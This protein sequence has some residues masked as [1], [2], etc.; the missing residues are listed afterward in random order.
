MSTE[1]ADDEIR[2]LASIP[3]KANAISIEGEDHGGGELK[4]AFSGSE[5]AP[6]LRLLA[7]RGRTL[8]VTVAPQQSALLPLSQAAPDDPA[9]PQAPLFQ[10]PIGDQAAR[11]ASVIDPDGSG[12]ATGGNVPPGHISV[13]NTRFQ[14]PRQVRRGLVAKGT[15]RK[16]AKA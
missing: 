10:A 6:V 15:R 3:A 14:R 2:F 5:I 1:M 12:V 4:L 7:L 9:F 8:L 13:A 16:K 11:V